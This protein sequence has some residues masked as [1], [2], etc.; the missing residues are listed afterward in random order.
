[1]AERDIQGLEQEVL[2]LRRIAW[3]LA[4]ANGGNVEISREQLRAFSPDCMVLTIETKI[5]GGVSVRAEV[6]SEA[7]AEPGAR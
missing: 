6:T 3:H 7:N 4:M 2:H 5:E 1:M